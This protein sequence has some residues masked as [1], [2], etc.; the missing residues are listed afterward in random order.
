MRSKRATASEQERLQ[1]GTRKTPFLSIKLMEAESP[2]DHKFFEPDQGTM[3]EHRNAERAVSSG[4]IQGGDE[5][6]NSIVQIG[7]SNR[8]FFEPEQG[9]EEQ[10]WPER[11]LRRRH[12][13]RKRDSS[14]LWSVDIPEEDTDEEVS[15]LIEASEVSSHV[16]SRLTAPVAALLDQ[17]TIFS[18][19]LSSPSRDTSSGDGGVRMNASIEVYVRT[20]T[21]EPDSS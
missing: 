12:L 9:T 14:R 20:G 3:E 21:M 4:V 5:M 1:I 7:G 8:E 11:Q 18:N 10:H 6:Q 15:D 16:V 2:M 13:A 19:G 17:D